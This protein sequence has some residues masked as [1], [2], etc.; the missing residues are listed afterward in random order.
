MRR[1][2]SL[3]LVAALALSACGGAATDSTT[4]TLGTPIT[5]PPGSTVPS[6]DPTTTAAGAVDAPEL[7]GTSWNVTDYR[8]PGGA[9]TNVWKTDVTISFSADGMVSGSAGCNEYQGMWAVSGTWNPFESG[10]PDPE[11]GQEL[12]LSSLSWTEMACDDQAIMEQEGEIL[13]LL[14]QAGRWVLIRGNFNLR[15]ADGSFLFEAEPA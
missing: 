15:D 7:G 1:N 8:T 3:I 10:V 12:T 6:D 2:L 9:I 4:T 14:Q 13:D 11:D 5:S